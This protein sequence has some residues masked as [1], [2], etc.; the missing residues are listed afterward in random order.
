MAALGS[1][2]NASRVSLIDDSVVVRHNSMQ[3][4]SRASYV[5]GMT[6]VGMAALQD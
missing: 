4:L 5:R 2:S 1:L 6:A 3:R